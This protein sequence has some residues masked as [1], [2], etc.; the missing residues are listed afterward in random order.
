MMTSH[1]QKQLQAKLRESPEESGIGIM[2]GR[3]CER[4]ALKNKDFGLWSLIGISALCGNGYVWMVIPDGDG[5]CDM[6]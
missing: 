6:I 2:G 3:H 4:R 5:P 1:V